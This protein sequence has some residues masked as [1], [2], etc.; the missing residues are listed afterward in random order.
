MPQVKDYRIRRHNAIVD[1]VSE[2][3]KSAGWLVTTEPK[4]TL[5]G[6][7]YKPDPILVRENKTVVID[8]TVVYEADHTLQ[9]AS[10]DDQVSTIG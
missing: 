4:I 8:P 9:S 2:K 1:C 3:C 10:Q 7:M 5:E 6:Q